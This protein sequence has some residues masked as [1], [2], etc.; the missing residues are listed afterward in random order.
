MQVRRHVLLYF[1]ACEL[2]SRQER[3]VRIEGNFLRYY[4][5]KRD[6][7]EIG[8]L[9][10]A[11]SDW[12]RPYDVTPECKTFEIQDEDRIFVFE[13]INP[14]DMKTWIDSIELVRMMAKDA[15]EAAKTAKLI[16]ETPPRIRYF[17]EH[18]EGAFISYITEHVNGIY[19]D[20]MIDALS[21][22][23]HIQAAESVSAYF[24]DFIQETR[25][26]ATRRARYDVLALGMDTI[27]SLLSVR[28]TPVMDLTS[29]QHQTASLGDIHKLIIWLTR[30]QSLLRRT[31]CP[32]PTPSSLEPKKFVHFDKIPDICS[33]YVNGDSSGDGGAASHLIE[34]CSKVVKDLFQNP[35]AMLQKHNDGSFFTNAPMEI[36]STLHQHL[37]LAAET[38]SAVLHVMIAD[39]ISAALE[40]ITLLII[41]H[42]QTLGASAN[43]DTDLEILCAL[44]NDNALHIEEII[45]VVNDFEM[46]EIRSSV[47]EIYDRV[48]MSLVECGQQCLARLTAV[49]MEDIEEPLAEVFTSDWLD[50]KQVDVAIATIDDYMNDF[51]TFLM[52]FWVPRFTANMLEAI[53]IR[54]ARSVVF[55]NDPAD[56]KYT[57]K[58]TLAK[59]TTTTATAAIKKSK[60]WLGYFRKKDEDHASG[61]STGVE[62]EVDDD[63]EYFICKAD[64]EALGRFQSF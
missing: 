54:Y 45:V 2:P 36:W 23:E 48:T 46:D 29:M 6:T 56:S 13:A 37:A 21:L 18:K 1:H 20:K 19:S 31:Y 30:H 50:G 33:R 32:L 41:D 59:R 53:I 28:L 43:R 60:A 17:D 34:Q 16:A 3:F 11:T 62:E 52:T 49:V 27:N 14:R 35:E 39:K 42:V 4:R 5:G 64:P 22:K 47:D 61:E 24:G 10:I 8:N 9:N 58:Q 51:Q 40:A 44:A 12:I 25:K 38:Q 26:T 55:R 7:E 57:R 15:D 63:M